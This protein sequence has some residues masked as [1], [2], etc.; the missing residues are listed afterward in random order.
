MSTVTNIWIPDTA[1]GVGN[2][3]TG[4][5]ALSSLTNGNNNTADGDQAL[6]DKTTGSD[7]TAMGAGTERAN[8]AGNRNTSIGAQ[9]GLARTSG[10]DNTTAGFAAMGNVTAGGDHNVGIG[11]QALFSYPGSFAVA[12]GSLALRDTTGDHN[13]AIGD[14][15]GLSVTTG[16]RSV[17]IGYRAG[18]AAGQHNNADNAIVI[19]AEAVATRDGQVV[20]GTAAQ[21]E[22]RLFDMTMFRKGGVLSFFAGNGGN[23]TATGGA[24]IV[25]GHT[26][27]L[28]LENADSN[29]LI[30]YEAGY[31]LT[32]GGNNVAV[33]RSALLSG[34][35]AR[36]C[37][38]V[39]A[40]AL[41]K[42]VDGV[43]TTAVGR[44]SLQCLVDGGNNTAIGDA[45]GRNLAGE[46]NC[47][48]GYGT[49]R[50]GF[51]NSFNV[52]IGQGALYNAGRAP[53]PLPEDGGTPTGPGTPSNNNAIVGHLAFELTTGGGHT[54][55]G[56]NAGRT[57][58]GGNDTIFI[59]RDA[60]FGEGQKVDATGSIVIGVGAVATRDNEVVIGS[61]THT[62]ATINGVTFTTEQLQAL[63]ALVS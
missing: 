32:S 29:T 40:G 59:G 8:P 12:I 21:D 25:I 4:R 51:G 57:L 62:H 14:Q 24:N 15:A 35:T 30:G 52:V 6:R 60:G 27:G 3:A 19:G 5:F 47:L 44:Y 43:G 34:V 54:G 45:S 56:K 36:D 38:A 17:Y 28:S 50:F 49:M 26:A 18:A 20:L 23:L 48:M 22:F 53:G 42:M 7:N 16:T 61:A 10:S 37:T 63:L 9:A 41:N 31:Y 1:T 55:I 2:T 11:R 13:T 46:Q 58:T 33:G 39:G